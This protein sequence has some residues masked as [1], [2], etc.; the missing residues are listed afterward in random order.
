MET[1]NVA[2]PRQ[3]KQYVQQRVA[4]GAYG[5]VSESV[6][7]LIRNEQVQTQRRK[8]EALLLEG[9]ESAPSVEVTDAHWQ[10]IREAALKPESSRSR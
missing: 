1:M 8:L 5:S 7:E 10:E 6:R 3:M 4:D 2:L 9:L